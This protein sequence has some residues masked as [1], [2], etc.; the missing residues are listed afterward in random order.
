MKKSIIILEDESIIALMLK[1]FLTAQ[2]HEIIGITKDGKTTIDLV[3]NSTPD[4]LIMDVHIRGSLNGIDTY[5]M[6]Q[7]FC[8]VPAIFLTGNSSELLNIEN[9]HQNSYVLEKPVS[10]TDLKRTIDVLFSNNS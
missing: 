10:L 2:N 7:Q 4:L 3:K 8:N 5:K 9:A 1:K 6:I